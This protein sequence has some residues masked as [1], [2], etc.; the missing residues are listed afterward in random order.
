MYPQNVFTN[1]IY[2]IYVKTGSGIKWLAMVDMP[3][4]QTKPNH[5]I[6]YIIGK[7]FCVGI[8]FLSFIKVSIFNSSEYSKLLNNIKFLKTK[9][10]ASLSL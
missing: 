3:W 5:Y 2:I 1:H 8:T 4:N 10:I 9:V 6:K 7:S